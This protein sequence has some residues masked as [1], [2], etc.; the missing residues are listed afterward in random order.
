MRCAP[1]A[2]QDA[3]RSPSWCCGHT[4]AAAMAASV[5]AATAEPL[6]RH[7][8]PRFDRDICEGPR[9][10]LNGVSITNV[11]VTAFRRAQPD[12]RSEAASRWTALPLASGLATA[13][14]SQRHC[15][16]DM[17]NEDGNGFAGRQLCGACDQPYSDSNYVATTA[18]NSSWC[19]DCWDAY[20]GVTVVVT[21]TLNPG[22]HLCGCGHELYAGP[23][24]AVDLAAQQV[25]YC[26][27]CSLAHWGMSN[28]DFAVT[29]I[30]D[31]IT[32]GSGHIASSGLRDLGFP[33][34]P[35]FSGLPLWT[36]VFSYGAA[37]S[38]HHSASV[39]RP[40]ARRGSYR[41]LWASHRLHHQS[42][43]SAFRLWPLII[44]L[45]WPLKA[46]QKR[47][48]Y[49]QAAIRSFAQVMITHGAHPS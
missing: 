29:T 31:S 1:D 46:S 22:I 45:M 34:A 2:S 41:Y 20:L 6:A 25:P 11:R 9:D 27:P 19:G 10:S 40:Y 15:V 39:S 13:D 8:V 24:F 33:A 32:M 28:S 47:N 38:A 49:L 36:L 4:A 21:T 42:A 7:S 18:D 48:N 37:H 3:T 12:G 26:R 14:D 23:W 35:F 16:D 5:E 43:T 17:E 44:H 30:T